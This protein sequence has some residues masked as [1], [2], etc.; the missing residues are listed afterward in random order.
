MDRL[1]E[2]DLEQE[3]RIKER[4]EQLTATLRALQEQ[5]VLRQLEKPKGLFGWLRGK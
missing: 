2:R 1:T 3:R 5:A 4:D